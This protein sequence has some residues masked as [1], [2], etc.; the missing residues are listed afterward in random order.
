MGRT[1]RGEAGSTRAGP[2]RRGAMSAADRRGAWPWGSGQPTRGGAQG[3]RTH[4]ISRR[5]RCPVSRDLPAVAAVPVLLLSLPPL[6]SED[7]GEEVAGALR[8][9]VS[10]T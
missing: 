4:C 8:R 7:A 5:H 10:V 1:W 9:E 6:H 3:P 2:R